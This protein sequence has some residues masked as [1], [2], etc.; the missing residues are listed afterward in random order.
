[1]FSLSNH[2]LP[3]GKVWDSA[4]IDRKVEKRISGRENLHMRQ[5]DC[6]L[7]KPRVRKRASS[8]LCTPAWV[9]LNLQRGGPLAWGMQ[10]C[11]VKRGHGVGPAKAEEAAR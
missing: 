10:E 4:G 7:D 1:M 8:S 2:I 3:V 11:R 6:S 5:G 9:I